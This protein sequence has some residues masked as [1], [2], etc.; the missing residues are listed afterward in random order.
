MR[1]PA[2]AEGAARPVAAVTAAVDAGAPDTGSA[3]GVVGEHAAR[4]PASTD[5]DNTFRDL[6]VTMQKDLSGAARAAIAQ[7]RPGPAS[8][9]FQVRNGP[10]SKCT[11]SDAR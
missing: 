9:P 8:Y 3:P 11:K 5:M 7:R 4:V 1:A 2:S 6:M 10:V